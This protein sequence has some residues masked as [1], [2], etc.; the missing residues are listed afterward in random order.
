MSHLIDLCATAIIVSLAAGFLYKTF[1]KSSGSCAS[2]GCSS[3]GSGC[4]NKIQHF[5]AIPIKSINK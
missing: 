5:K 1:K 2:G 4:S 3:C